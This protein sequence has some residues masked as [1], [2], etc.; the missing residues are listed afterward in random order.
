M[1]GSLPTRKPCKPW[2]VKRWSGSRHS[3]QR[4]TPSRPSSSRACLAI[5]SCH[6]DLIDELYDAARLLLCDLQT[7]DLVIYAASRMLVSWRLNLGKAEWHTC[8]G[9]TAIQP[10]GCAAFFLQSILHYRTITTLLKP[11]RS[12]LPVG[13]APSQELCLL[14]LCWSTRR[15]YVADP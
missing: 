3:S 9:M 12:S 4:K 10:P 11:W 15:V 13:D 1:E 6:G 7:R 2:T 5:L 14:Q 8:D